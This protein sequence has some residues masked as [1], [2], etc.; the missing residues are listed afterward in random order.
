M[1]LNT[2]SK[3]KKCSVCWKKRGKV[4]TKNRNRKRKK[5][6]SEERHVFFFFIFFPINFCFYLLLYFTPSSSQFTGTLSKQTFIMI[7]ITSTYKQITRIIFFPLS[8]LQKCKYFFFFSITSNSENQKYS[9]TV[10]IH[11]IPHLPIFLLLLS[12]SSS[13]LSS[14]LIFLYWLCWFLVII[15]SF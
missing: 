6:V 14:S 8:W 10:Y 3:E 13:P 15:I 5:N 1:I 9:L 7:V 12:S 2:L 11:P 4:E